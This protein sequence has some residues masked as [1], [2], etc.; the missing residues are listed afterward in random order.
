MPLQ[1]PPYSAKAVSNFFL[2]KSRKITQMKLHKLLYYAH[3]WHLGLTSLPLLDEMVEAWHHSPIVPSVFHEFKLFGS[4]PIT[5]FAREFNPDEFA[6]EIVPSVDVGD[7][8]V[9]D[10]LERIWKVYNGFSDD[11]LFH[12]T[13]AVGSPWSKTHNQHPGI[14]GVDIPNQLFAEHFA[15]RVRDNARS[16]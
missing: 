3:G 7:T 14:K 11:Q 10:L 15:E 2:A 16:A 1:Q 9:H 12:M 4:R 8:F 13:R 5:C 6:R